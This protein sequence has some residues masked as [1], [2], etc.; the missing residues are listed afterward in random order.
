MKIRG[1]TANVA[2]LLAVALTS[3]ATAES[4]PPP[5]LTIAAGE[6]WIFRVREGQPV[7]ARKVDQAAEPAEGELKVTLSHSMG[8]TM[9][10]T[11]NDATWYNYRAFITSNPGRSGTPT[12]VCTLMG[13]GRGAFENWPQPLPAIRVTDFTP[14]AEGEMSCR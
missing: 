1:V 2:L 13:G 6:S 4:L 14:A 3:P 5:G 8:T 10:V 7:D 11:N 12:S 9:S